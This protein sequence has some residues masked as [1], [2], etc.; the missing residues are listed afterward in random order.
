[1]LCNN[2][3]KLNNLAIA[4]LGG[5][6]ERTGDEWWPHH[7]LFCLHTIDISGWRK[8]TSEN[9]TLLVQNCPTIKT[10]YASHCYSLSPGSITAANSS[11][12]FETQPHLQ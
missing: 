5:S 10:V 4:H 8:A 6:E 9:L 1:M 11:A 7:G 2:C 3:P 12:V